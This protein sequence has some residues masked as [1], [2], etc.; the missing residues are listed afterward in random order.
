M[1]QCVRTWVC[2]LSIHV[3]QVY[4]PFSSDGAIG[5]DRAGK[6]GIRVGLIMVKTMSW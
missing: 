6:G 3:S 2:I 5:N 1:T 4:G